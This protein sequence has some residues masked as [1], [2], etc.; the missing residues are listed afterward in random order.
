MAYTTLSDRPSA[1]EILA[2]RAAPAGA[3]GAPSAVEGATTF[4]G[5]RARTACRPA[6][7]ARLARQARR[8]IRSFVF[9][10]MQPI[11]PRTGAATACS[12]ATWPGLAPTSYHTLSLL[13]TGLA[14]SSCFV[15]GESVGP[16][17]RVIRGAPAGESFPSTVR[18][19]HGSR[20]AFHERLD[21]LD[22][23]DRASRCS[24]PA[25]QEPG[26]LLAVEGA[27][28]VRDARC[29]H[30]PDG[31]GVCSRAEHRVRW[32]PDRDRGTAPP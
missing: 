2:K 31:A 17:S 23:I 16:G 30:G 21:P 1:V 19:G 9:F 10:V 8:M 28:R 22:R 13:A 18:Q 15:S 32:A 11:P 26:T 6:I 29:H 4:L 7:T 5:L 27:A 14:A 12:S 24:R 25:Q 3:G 20:R